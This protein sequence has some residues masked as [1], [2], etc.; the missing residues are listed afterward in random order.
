M[1]I[2]TWKCADPELEKEIR[3][4]PYASRSDVPRLQQIYKSRQTAEESRTTV[5]NVTGQNEIDNRTEIIIHI[6]RLFE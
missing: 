2:E 5:G 4:F 1:A 6:F 3:C